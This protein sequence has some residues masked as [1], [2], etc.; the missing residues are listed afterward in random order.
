MGFLTKD[1]EHVCDNSRAPCASGE[2]KHSKLLP[3]VPRLG[4]EE[5]EVV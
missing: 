4:P 2:A 1:L 3:L 5:V